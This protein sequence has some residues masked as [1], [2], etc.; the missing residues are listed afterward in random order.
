MSLRVIILYYMPKFG[1]GIKTTLLESLRSQ[2]K[3]I[4]RL[5]LGKTS[6]KDLVFVR[7][8]FLR[9][10]GAQNKSLRFII[11]YYMLKYT[12][13]IKKNFARVTS[14]QKKNPIKGS[15]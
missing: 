3:H 6:Y 7:V 15:I 11:I 13:G 5:D 14:E 10:I 2:K 4:Q 8:E 1:I 9:L 12:F